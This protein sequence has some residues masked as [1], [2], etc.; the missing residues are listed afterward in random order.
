VRVF[1]LRT[2]VPAI[3]EPAE[4]GQ[5][6]REKEERAEKAPGVNRTPEN[7][8][9]DQHQDPANH[10]DTG[11]LEKE[12]ETESL[13]LVLVP[14][15]EGAVLFSCHLRQYGLQLVCRPG[16]GW[17]RAKLT[18]RLESDRKP[19]ARRVQAPLEDDAEMMS[20]TKLEQLL[21]GQPEEIR[22]EIIRINTDARPLARQVA[23][24]IPILAGLV[25]LFNSFRMMRLLDP[26]P[27]GS[28][29]EMALG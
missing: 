20:N 2:R 15:R 24:F 21:V 8:K 13:V 4:Q 18:S 5:P 26:A 17:G 3:P 1:P 10:A 14:R 25:G 28:V 22:D 19:A 27:S 7:Q 6:R 23:L 29:G 11:D 9:K 12:A 16:A